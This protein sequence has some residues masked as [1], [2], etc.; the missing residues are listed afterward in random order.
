MERRRGQVSLEPRGAFRWLS[1]P[2]PLLVFFNGGDG[3]D[4][5]SLQA[6]HSPIFAM[7]VAL[8]FTPL[9]GRSS[10]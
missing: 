5:D 6:K 2:L 8:V 9:L 3:G 7:L 10:N 1:L 4:F